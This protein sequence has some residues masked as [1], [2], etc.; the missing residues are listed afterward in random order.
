MA[1]AR[2]SSKFVKQYTW[3]ISDSEGTIV[4]EGDRW[5]FFMTTAVTQAEGNIDEAAGENLCLIDRNAFLPDRVN[6]I[7]Y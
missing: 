4:K 7:F 5:S 2:G 3:L 6:I 1:E